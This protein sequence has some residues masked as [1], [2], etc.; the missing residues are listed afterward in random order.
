MLR[1]LPYAAGNLPDLIGSLGVLI[2]TGNVAELTIGLRDLLSQ[3]A[4]GRP[5]HIILS[6]RNRS[7]HEYDLAVGQHLEKFSF[8]SFSS[9]VTDRLLSL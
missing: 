7:W 8:D 9:R 5:K 4:H 3:F 1:K 2:P 6:N